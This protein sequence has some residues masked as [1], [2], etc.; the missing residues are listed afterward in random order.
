[1]NNFIDKKVLIV[2]C[3]GV[4]AYKSLELIRYLKKNRSEVKTILTKSATKFVTKL[5]VSA[6]SNE[7][8]YTDLFDHK[9]ESEMSHIQLSRWADFILICPATANTI[10]KLSMGNADD[11]ASTVVLASNKKIFIVPAMNV[12][13]WEHTSN[14]QNIKKLKEYGYKFIG[15]EVGDMACGEYGQGKMVEPLY[16]LKVLDN[17]LS[18]LKKNKKFKALVTAGPTIEAID[19]VRFISNHSSGKQGYEIAKSFSENGFDTTLISGPTQIPKPDNVYTINVVTANEMYEET[20]KRL[21]VD[22]AVFAA[23]VTDFKVKN[24]QKKKIKKKIDLSLKFELNKDILKFV[25]Q[26]NFLRPKIV[27]GFAAETNDLNSN[28]LIK[29]KEKNCDWIIGNDVRKK[30]TG[31]G[32]DY[33]KVSLFYNGKIERF[34]KMH[35]ASIADEIVERLIS[36]LN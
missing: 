2:I 11:L 28:S 25:S 13:M 22:V 7:K 20:K 10:S 34:E 19:P 35:K 24:Y 23:A 31:F 9:L 4:A 14:K 27:V 15:P 33:N 32:S 16:I 12:R 36:E 17:Y 6:L 8:V 26:N 1:M 21:P 5:S 30:D 3:G 29:L 18:Q